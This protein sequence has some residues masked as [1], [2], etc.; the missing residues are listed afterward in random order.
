[1]KI[2]K[3]VGAYYTSIRR[4]LLRITSYG[5]MLHMIG[6]GMWLSFQQTVPLRAAAASDGKGYKNSGQVRRIY[7]YEYD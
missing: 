4:R 5:E 1:M 2:F 3:T 6:S 7:G